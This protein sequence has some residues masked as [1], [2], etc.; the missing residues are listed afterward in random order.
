MIQK[1]AGAVSP[2][3]GP[4]V[5]TVMAADP[6]APRLAVGTDVVSCVLSINVVAKSTPFHRMTE[7]EMKLE[8]CA[9]R[10]CVALPTSALVGVI[11]PRAGIAFRITHVCESLVPPPGRGF[12]TEMDAVRADPSSLAGTVAISCV[13]EVYV[14]VSGTDAPCRLHVTAD[15]G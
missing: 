6:A 10:S 11:E 12:V 5:S 15:P 13:G 3:P 8:P 9:A 4:G 2:P 7:P 14:N 1:V